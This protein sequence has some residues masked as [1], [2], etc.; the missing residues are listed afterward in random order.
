VLI[1]DQRAIGITG[2]LLGASYEARARVA[3]WSG[4]QAGIARY[5]TLTA[6]EYRHGHNSALGARYERLLREAHGAV[7][8]QLPTLADFQS[9]LTSRMTRVHDGSIAQS[10]AGDSDLLDITADLE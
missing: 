4:D 3:I 10:I 1:A 5:L 7:Q 8:A 9:S 2:L 6:T